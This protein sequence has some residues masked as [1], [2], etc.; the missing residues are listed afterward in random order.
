MKIGIGVSSANASV[1]CLCHH[2]VGVGWGT[3]VHSFAEL[4]TWTCTEI[5]LLQSICRVRELFNGRT[6]YIS[7]PHT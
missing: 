7:L 5:T 1:K 6:A 3:C 4:S 2:C